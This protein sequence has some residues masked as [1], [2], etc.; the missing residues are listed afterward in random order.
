[1]KAWTRVNFWVPVKRFAQADVD[2]ILSARPAHM[3]NQQE[4]NT[5][6]GLIFKSFLNQ[7]ERFG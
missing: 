7:Q 1:L 2:E 5:K 4:I 6:T 3:P